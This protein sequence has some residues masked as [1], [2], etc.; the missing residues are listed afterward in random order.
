MGPYAVGVQQIERDS[1]WACVDPRE[2]AGQMA[3]GLWSGMS[4]GQG[5]FL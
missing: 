2:Q 4:T 3:Q 5:S 1:G